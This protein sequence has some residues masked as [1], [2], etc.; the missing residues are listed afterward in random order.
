MVQ[1]YFIGLKIPEKEATQLDEI[2]STWNLQATHK[3][4]PHVSDLHVTLVYLGAVEDGVMNTLIERLEKLQGDLPAFDMEITGVSNFGSPK[5]PRV[6]FAS[7]EEEPKLKQ[8]QNNV[9]MIAESVPLKLDKKPYVPHIT[10]AKKWDGNQELNMSDLKIEPM[11][12]AIKQFS[13][14][15]IHPQKAPS[16][17]AVKTF[18]LKDA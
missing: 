13:V 10:L 1:H 5:N 17:N 18:Q 6:I 12:A 14:F 8:L 11:T 3:V 7:L 2:R 4:I 16:Y 15:S 9:K